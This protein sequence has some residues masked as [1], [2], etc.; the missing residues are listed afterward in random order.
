MQTLWKTF[1]EKSLLVSIRV[2]MADYLN[3]QD[4]KHVI[5]GGNV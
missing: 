1:D 3:N 5:E 2:E 4:Q